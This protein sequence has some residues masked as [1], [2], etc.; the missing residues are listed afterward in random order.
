[1][2][3]AF[4]DVDGGGVGSHR[5]GGRRIGREVG[6]REDRRLKLGDLAVNR[7]RDRNLDH[8]RSRRRRRRYR[9]ARA[10][11]EG[12]EEEKSRMLNPPWVSRFPGVH[13]KKD[14]ALRAC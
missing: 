3:R 4:E 7:S 8:H 6:D 11:G 5:V 9:R 13:T 12:E 14:A 2:D 10:E 1:M